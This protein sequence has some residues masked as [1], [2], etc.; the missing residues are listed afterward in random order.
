MSEPGATCPPGLTLQQYNNIDYGVCDV[1]K[2]SNFVPTSFLSGG[3]N[4]SEV[5]G[6]LK[7]YQYKSPN[8]FPLVFDSNASPNIKNFKH[9]C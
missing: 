2:D 7:G 1:F 8:G 4:Y 6:Q 9:I 5:C 3:N